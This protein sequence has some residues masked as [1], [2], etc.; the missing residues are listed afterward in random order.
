[1]TTTPT[2]CL[3]PLKTYT[4]LKNSGNG[5]LLFSSPPFNTATLTHEVGKSLIEMPSPVTT[6]KRNLMTYFDSPIKKKLKTQLLNKTNKLHSK[7][8]IISKMKKK[9]EII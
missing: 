7:V 3:T 5:E 4:K 2:K 9:K 1:M 6:R 8:A